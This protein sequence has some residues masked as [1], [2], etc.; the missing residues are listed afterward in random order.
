[1]Q[2]IEAAMAMIF[3]R[4]NAQEFGIA[5]D[6][7]CAAGFS[8]GGHLCGCLANLFDE[9]VLKE[10]FSERAGFIRPDAAILAYPVVTSVKKS[11]SGSFSN[12][13]GDDQELKKYLSL[14]NR[15]KK[16]S[17]PAFL[18]HTY[19]DKSVPVY[20]SLVYALACEKNGVPFSLHIFE[21]GGHG[22]A[23]AQL[24]TNSQETLADASSSVEQWIRLSVDWLKDRDIK[25][26]HIN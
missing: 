8:A 12:L 14:E 26:K 22:L 2:L 20:N 15:V 3:I 24:D 4:E 5:K 19:G 6:M 25:L 21:K 7:V 16:D 11:H 9:P 23:T 17:S 13:C 1:V 10:K 18:W